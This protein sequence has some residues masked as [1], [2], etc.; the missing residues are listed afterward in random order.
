MTDTPTIRIAAVT[1]SSKILGRSFTDPFRFSFVRTQQL[2]RLELY[3]VS[4]SR[5]PPIK[6]LS[7]IVSTDQTQVIAEGV[8]V[9]RM[10]CRLVRLFDFY[11][12][13]VSVEPIA[14][15]FTVFVILIS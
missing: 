3:R 6:P 12:I 1:V 13:I 7:I 10:M 15:P 5:I 4:L 11:V 8:A 9:R 2:R 14:A